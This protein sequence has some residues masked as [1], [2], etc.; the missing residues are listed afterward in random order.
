MSEKKLSKKQLL[1]LSSLIFGMF[2]GAGNL[3]FPVQLGQTAGHN[4]LPATLGFLVTGCLV[5]FLAMLAVSLTNSKSIS[6]VAA[7]V[8]PWFGT[9]V[10]VVVHF[11][12]GPLFGTPRTAATAFSMG[13]APFVPA[14]YQQLAMLVFSAVFFSL[15]YFLTVKQSN[16][17]KWIG[18][19]LN[20]LFLVLLVL[21]LV[22]ALVLP[23]G[24]LNQHTAAAYQSHAGFQGI[25]DGY[26]TMDGLALLAF[27]VTAVYAVRN[28]GFEGHSV[29]KVLAKAGLLSIFWEALLYLALVL[30][31]VSSLGKFSTAANGGTAFSQIVTHYTG[32]LGVLVTGV[33]VTLAVFTTAMGLFGSFAQ[34]LH[35]AF[36]KVAYVWWLRVIAVGSFVTANAGLTN[37]V[38]W[39]VPVLML[40][41]PYA[42]ALI[43]LG[44]LNKW[45]NQSPYLYRS[46]VAFVTVPAFLDALASSPLVSVSFVNN[47]VTGYH[48][49]F[50]MAA[51]GF[52]WVVPAL[53]GAAFG[54]AWQLVAKRKT[55]DSVEE[56]TVL[57][58][59][60]V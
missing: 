33:I 16:L 46:V 51:D 17:M 50:P 14:A 38:K 2:F 26:N 29:S 56:E 32:N 49:Y 58:E 8:A 36:P 6:D 23:M 52:G 53:V 31:G 4:W 42:L 54:L 27:S 9:L 43:S 7:P 40:L 25:L 59:E 48:Q 10:L 1:L 57:Q 19:Y 47:L 28:M 44:V 12:I 41:Y 3:I 18:K 11:T 60:M 30:L 45:V 21:L 39:S 37:I 34:D 5:P 13:V 24:D 55:A 15:A 35:R 20:P 22:L